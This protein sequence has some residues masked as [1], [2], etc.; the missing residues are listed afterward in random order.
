[1][2][3]AL[4]LTFFLGCFFLTERRINNQRYDCCCCFKSKQSEF[5]QPGMPPAS[6]WT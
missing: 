3:W 2:D 5:A 1:M 6:W 4:Q